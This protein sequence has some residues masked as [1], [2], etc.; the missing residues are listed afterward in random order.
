MIGCK[1]CR[2]VVPVDPVV[3]Y[4]PHCGCE[5]VYVPLGAVN[6]IGKIVW[7]VVQIMGII[8]AMLFVLFIIVMVI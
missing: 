8:M 7:D 2:N 4:C 5:M 1:N 3:E 6:F